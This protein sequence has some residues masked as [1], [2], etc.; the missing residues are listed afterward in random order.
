MQVDIIVVSILIFCQESQS[1]KNFN[2][3]LGLS[4]WF[5]LTWQVWHRDVFPITIPSLSVVSVNL[6]HTQAE[7]IALK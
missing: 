5:S 4:A 3:V 1:H 2:S 7:W 6:P